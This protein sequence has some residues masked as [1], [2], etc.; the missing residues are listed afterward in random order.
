MSSIKTQ[1]I[2][3]L[4]ISLKRINGSID[5]TI[6]AAES[7]YTFNFDIADNVYRKF[8]YIDEINDFPTICLYASRDR[9]SHIGAAVKY[10]TFT[11][12]IRGYIKSGE[13]SI[14]DSDNLA[15]DIEYVIE[16]FNLDPDRC[17]INLVDSRILSIETDEGLMN[18][19]GLCEVSVEIAYEY[20]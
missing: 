12:T 18:P 19:Y 10:G 14:D 16:S 6:G 11:V 1:I 20:A 8:K 3:E 15:N 4:V 2:D 13:S 7:P 9:R 5:T 17:S